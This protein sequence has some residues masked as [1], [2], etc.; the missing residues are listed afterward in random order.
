MDMT[1]RPVIKTRVDKFRNSGGGIVG[2]TVL[3]SDVGM[4]NSDRVR[5]PFTG[6]QGRREVVCDSLA[7]VADPG[8]PRSFSS[9][10]DERFR[11]RLAAKCENVRR[12]LKTASPPVQ[13][14]MISV[15]DKHGNVALGQPFH[16]TAE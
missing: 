4:K 6:S 9:S 7:R 8:N 2:M 14:V 5:R 10:P 12:K 15:H 16:F 13:R 11:V 1:Q 3:V